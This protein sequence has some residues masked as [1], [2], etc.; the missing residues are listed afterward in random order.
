MSENIE[1]Y[2]VLLPFLSPVQMD[3]TLS[4]GCY[5]LPRLFAHL[6]ACCCVKT[7]VNARL[8]NCFCVLLGVVASVCTPLP[9]AV[10]TRT[11]QLPA[12]LDYCVRLYVA[13]PVQ[14][15]KTLIFF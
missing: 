11:Q 1:T 6:V 4:H 3:A 14:I 2:V 8:G 12:L 5:L 9:T 7:K 10:L 15:F 13:L